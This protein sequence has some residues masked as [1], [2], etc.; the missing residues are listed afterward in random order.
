MI[1]FAGGINIGPSGRSGIYSREQ[2]VKDNPDVIIILNMGI[3]TEEEKKRWL[4]YKT[5]NAVKNNRIYIID[6]YKLGSL[7]PVSFVNSLKEIVEILHEKK[8]Y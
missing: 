7:T 5:I 8:T 1:E 3:A 6:S 4:K 2:A